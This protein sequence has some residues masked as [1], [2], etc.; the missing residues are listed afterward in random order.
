MP[1]VLRLVG[2]EMAAKCAKTDGSSEYC[3]SDLSEISPS[4]KVHCVV[5]SLSP[6]KGSK[7]RRYFLRVARRLALASFITHEIERDARR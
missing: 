2:G 1:R 4:A 6:M 5:T 7:E 3:V